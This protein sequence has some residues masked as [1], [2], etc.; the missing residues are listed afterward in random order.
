MKKL[1][2]IVLCFSVLLVSCNRTQSDTSSD[3]FSNESEV[4][5][6][7]SSASSIPSNEISE[8]TSSNEEIFEFAIDAKTA[9][10]RISEEISLTAD[11]VEIDR[12][13]L[14]EKTTI[15]ND[16]YDDFCGTMSYEL[17]NNSSV[18]VFCCNT[19]VK[20]TN[21]KKHIENIVSD[22]SAH[23]FFDADTKI[24]SY[25]GY[26]IV[27]TTQNNFDEENLVSKLIQ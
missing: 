16:M 25:Q 6:E 12:H 26:T 11:T 24:I 23:S 19:A 1:L 8:V 17:S 10:E 15:S 5:S 18:L 14:F 27:V 7:T 9:V 22:I 21:L 3:T 4:I 13:F 20:A 2:I